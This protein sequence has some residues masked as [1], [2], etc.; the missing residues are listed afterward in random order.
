MTLLADLIRKRKPREVATV[1]PAIPATQQGNKKGKIA[2]IATVAVASPQTHETVESASNIQQKI[3]RHKVLTML[4][5]N[6]DTQRAIYTDTASDPSNVI[7]T[8]AVRHAAICEMLID[9]SK[10]DP[11]QLLALTEQ[12]GVQNVH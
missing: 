11:W 9:K 5:E 2:K 10:Y 12:L 8:I 3:R 4:K 1:I 7:L 6:P